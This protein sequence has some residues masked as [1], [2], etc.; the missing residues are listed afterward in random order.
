MHEEDHADQRHDDAFLDQRALERI[1]GT[2]DQR[3]TVIDRFH[4]DA[5]GKARGDLRQTLFDAFDDRQRVL[6]VALERDA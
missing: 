1:D 6:A 3:R 5:F 2:I 4:G